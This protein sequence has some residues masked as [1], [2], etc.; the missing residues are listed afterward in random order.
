MKIMR[1]GIVTPIVVDDSPF[2][3]WLAYTIVS[4]QSDLSNR[5]LD[6]KL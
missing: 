4:A 1:T 5:A 2:M 3:R 6:N